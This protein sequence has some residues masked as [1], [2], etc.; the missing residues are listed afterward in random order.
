M[1]VCGCTHAHAFL[2]EIVPLNPC[3]SGVVTMAVV[4]AVAMVEIV[5]AVAEIVVLMI[6]DDS[7]VPLFLHF[8]P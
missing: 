6:C 7:W 3:G 2:C 8:P 5:V 1:C 4:V